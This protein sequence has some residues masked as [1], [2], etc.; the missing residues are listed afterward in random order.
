ME[1][2]NGFMSDADP[3]ELRLVDRPHSAESG[4]H[5]KLFAGTIV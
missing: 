2:A 3:T 5:S 1:K 4:S